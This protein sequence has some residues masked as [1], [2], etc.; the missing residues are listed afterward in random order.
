MAPGIYVADAARSLIGRKAEASG[1]LSGGHPGLPLDPS[2]EIR[3]RRY[4]ADKRP[5]VPLGDNVGR[6]R[7]LPRLLEDDAE[8]L[9]L[10]TAEGMVA[11]YEVP[12]VI[13]PGRG[14]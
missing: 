5:Y 8:A 12:W 10:V 2:Q 4:P 11:Y 7:A 1:V 13:K 3:G 9:F 14:F 6:Q